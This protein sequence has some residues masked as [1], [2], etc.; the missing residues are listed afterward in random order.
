MPQHTSS[1]V[2]KCSADT[3]RSFLGRPV[4][5]PQISN[6]DLKLEI[7]S[8]PEL[9]TVGERIEFRITALGIKQRA[10]H[11]YVQVEQGIIVET[12]I[13]GSLRAWRHSQK[14]EVATGGECRLTDEVEFEPPGG[15]LGFVMNEKR[16][17]ESL[18]EGM[19]FRYS[20]LEELIASGVI[21]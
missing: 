4:N 20:A 11:E 14:I 19:E 13:E 8:A 5:F 9:V 16:I 1:S 15:M 17:R 7:I 10:I 6:P 18:N 3:L 2:L 21:S 12:L